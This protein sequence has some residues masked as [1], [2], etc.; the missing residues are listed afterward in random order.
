[1]KSKTVAA[2]CLALTAILPATQTF[3]RTGEE[4]GTNA[5]TK[6]AKAKVVELKLGGFGED[7]KPQN[8]FGPSPMNFRAKLKMLQQLA[9]DPAVTGVVLK[10]NG[11]PDFARSLDVMHELRRVKSA[12]KKVA[13]YLE[14]VDQRT[15]MFASLS[16]VLA[17][18]PS[19]AIM[20]EG[21]NAEIMYM[22]DLL[23]ML[24][25]K[26][27][28]LH[29]GEFKTA[30]EE[31]TKPG[32]TPEQ[33]KT[34]EAI[35]DEQYQQMVATIAENRG[36]A[37]QAVE[38]MFDKVMIQPDDAKAAGLISHVA[39]EDQF[40][41]QCERL[42]GGPFDLDKKYGR[43]QGEDIE[44]M[45]ENPFGVFQLIGKM[46]KPQEADLPAE[47]RIAVIY[48]TGAITSGKSQSGFDG[49]V[50]SM[51]SETIVAALEKA[52]N[53]DW[54]KAV[55]LRVN[56]PGGSALASDMIW[57]AVERVREKKPIISSMGS[58]AASGGY[59]I[60]MGCD[61]IM[62]QPS[63][64]TGSIGV[65]SMLPDVS[66]VMK[67]FGVK[68]ETVGKGPRVAE[69]SMM[70]TGPSEFLKNLITTSMQDTYQEF[71]TKA[72][73][74]R[75]TTKD[76]IDAIARGRV[77]T[78]RQALDLNLVDRLGSFEDAIAW[79]CELGGNL[80]P[81]TTGVV[82]YPN[83]PNFLEQFQDQMDEM[84]LAQIVVQRGLIELGFGDLVAV[85]HAWRNPSRT[86]SKENVM[87]L[88]PFTVSI[89]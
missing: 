46:M 5:A 30:Y 89:R 66:G 78:G 4:S 6:P 87:A 42:F 21:L 75:K 45:L 44:K 70:G 69:L 40:D 52:R 41:A 7:P 84:T 39:Y 62:A 10:V 1:M 25:V 64:I 56:S 27:H 38:S 76:A 53:D 81:K 12:G 54:V 31:L 26:V 23:E 58:V 34:L 65:V 16:D 82:E 33:R 24:N 17:V 2:L 36:M 72:A 79:A 55:V 59:W 74:G 50:S 83:A 67:R 63:T 57:R 15:L 29:V 19:G 49:E 61:R 85:A 37:A 22:R 43:T 48:A 14:T 80:D 88:L 35:L 47:P 73:N 32:M 8:P 3:A 77:W 71:L 51:G 86:W 13:C 11:S 28:V 60:S 68:V 20:L 9:A 18:P